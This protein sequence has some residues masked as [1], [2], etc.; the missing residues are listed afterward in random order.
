M[1]G[2]ICP[3]SLNWSMLFLGFYPGSCILQTICKNETAIKAEFPST[4]KA[5][6]HMTVLK[7]M[8]N[9]K[10]SPLDTILREH[11]MDFISNVYLVQ[12]SMAS[13]LV[14]TVLHNNNVYNTCT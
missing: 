6:L 9:T 14:V 3:S 12:K 1:I 7:W 5:K 8:L 2:L 11:Y 10:Y 13:F 4:D